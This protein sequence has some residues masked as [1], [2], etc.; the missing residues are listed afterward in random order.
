MARPKMIHPTRLLH[1]ALPEA[2]LT[3]VD[4][5]LWSEVEQRVPKGAYQAFLVP[6]IQ[7][8]LSLTTLQLEAFGAPHGYYIRGQKEMVEWLET[9]LKGAAK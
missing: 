7:E 6:M 5:L 3:R 1:V 4:L 2:L 8:Q 9:H